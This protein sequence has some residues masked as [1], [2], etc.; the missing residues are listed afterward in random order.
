[1]INF[2]I[3]NNNKTKYH[4]NIITEITFIFK[5]HLRNTEAEAKKVCFL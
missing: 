5:K 1:M 4:S 2:F 3:R